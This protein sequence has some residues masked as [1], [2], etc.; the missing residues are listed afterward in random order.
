MKMVPYDY[1]KI[2]K[3]CYYKSTKNDVIL[4]EFLESGETCVELVGYTHVSSKC[5]QNSLWTRIKKRKMRNTIKVMI[6]GDQV[7]LVRIDKIEDAG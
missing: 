2:E 4:N 6:R 7:F 3:H 5:F 1:R